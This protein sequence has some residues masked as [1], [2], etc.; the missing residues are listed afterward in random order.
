[1][2]FRGKRETGSGNNQSAVTVRRSKN[3]VGKETSGAG[4]DVRNAG[5]KELTA[6]EK[7]PTQSCKLQRRRA[8]LADYEKGTTRGQSIFGEKGEGGHNKETNSDRLAL[9][10]LNRLPHPLKDYRQGT[11]WVQGRTATPLKEA[12]KGF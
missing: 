8:S 4:K 2:S 12:G 5:K 6:L 3:A 9:G 1:V 10:G 7:G 11:F